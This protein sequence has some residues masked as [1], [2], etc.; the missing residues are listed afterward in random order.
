MIKAINIVKWPRKSH[1]PSINTKQEFVKLEEVCKPYAARHLIVEN[2]IKDS[3]FALGVH[4]ADLHKKKISIKDIPA[5]QDRIRYIDA[6]Y[7]YYQHIYDQLLGKL[8]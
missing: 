5:N 8:L 2:G 7:E 6:Q 1:C 4:L 3:V